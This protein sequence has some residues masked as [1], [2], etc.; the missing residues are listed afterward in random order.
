[1]KHSDTRVSRAQSE[2]KKTI[3]RSVKIQVMIWGKD[4]CKQSD[5]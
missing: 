2:E 1:M 4:G 5:Y 3:F